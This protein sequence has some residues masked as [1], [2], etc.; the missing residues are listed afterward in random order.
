MWKFKSNYTKEEKEELKRIFFEQTKCLNKNP[1]YIFGGLL[2]LI[3][4]FYFISMALI[5]FE[6]LKVN[7][8]IDI[9]KPLLTGFLGGSVATILYCF[10]VERKYLNVISVFL[11][12][13]GMFFSLFLFGLRNKLD[14]Q[15][16]IYSIC[17]TVIYCCI[18]DAVK[19]HMCKAIFEFTRNKDK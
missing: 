13:L 17:L 2:Y 10:L 6:N 15:Y 1:A 5:D 3:L 11:Y 16:M 19:K 9:S 8:M 7:S 14:W 18:V 4:G 12:F